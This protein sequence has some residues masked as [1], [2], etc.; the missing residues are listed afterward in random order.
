M[1]I[2]FDKLISEYEQGYK[3]KNNSV[4]YYC[5]TTE[6]EDSSPRFETVSSVLSSR[7]YIQ[8][9]ELLEISRWKAESRRNDHYIN[10]NDP[11]DIEQYSREALAASTAKE[12]IDSLMKIRGVGVPVASSVL[13]IVY[14]SEYAIIDYRALR[15]LGIAQPNLTNP[16]N[17][18]TYST[19]LEHIQ[20]YGQNKESY[21][22]YMTHIREI[23]SNHNLTPR[24]VDM[25]LWTY[26]KRTA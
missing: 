6:Y 26:D 2:R 23:A 16:E 12:A 18:S 8:I 24:E 19:F 25:A 7:G 1:N 11:D 10:E 13:T 5:E 20:D 17:Y 14:P 15:A 22:F 4:M 9:Q 3:D 21:E